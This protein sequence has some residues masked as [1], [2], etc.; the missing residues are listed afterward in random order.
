MRNPTLERPGKIDGEPR[1]AGA[2][3]PA[4]IDGGADDA[5]LMLRFK[6][7]DAQ[8]F[9]D[10]YARHRG[11]LYRYFL[12][13]APRDAADDLYQE[14]WLKVIRGAVGYSAAAPFSAYL[15]RIA[16]N[17]LVDH[18]RRAARGALDTGDDGLP[19]LPAPNE[20]LD[21]AFDRASLKERLSAAIAALPPPQ[22]EAFLLREETDLT[23]DEIAAVVGATRETVKSRLRYAVQRLRRALG[24]ADEPQERRA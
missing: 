2:A 18:Y 16:H 7:G 24:D 1:T 21:A 10:L 11:P 14:T 20:P 13:Q 19:D 6:A 12:R 5:R 22:R 15:Y 3:A 17:V 4:R 9:H 23:L 8:A